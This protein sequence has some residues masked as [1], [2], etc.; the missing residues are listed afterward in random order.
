M[1]HSISIMMR[2]LEL[3]LGVVLLAIIGLNFANVVG[4]YVFNSSILGAEEVQVFV[5]V[6]IAFVGAGIVTWRNMHLRM[7]AISKLLPAAVQKTLLVAEFIVCLI[8]VGYTIMQSWDYVSRML[9]LGS[10]SDVAHVP[11]WIAHSSVLVGLA[12]VIVMLLA[13]ILTGGGEQPP[14]E[15]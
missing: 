1:K 13:V 3:L 11:M 14:A 8:V 4:R 12:F 6:W 10:A 7:D 9:M 15:G 2:M 5:L